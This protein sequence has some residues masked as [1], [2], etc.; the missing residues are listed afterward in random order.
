MGENGVTRRGGGYCPIL[1]LGGRPGFPSLAL[2]SPLRRVP[3]ARS[4]WNGLGSGLFLA[5][6]IVRYSH[7]MCFNGLVNNGLQYGADLAPLWPMKNQVTRL[8]IR[9][10]ARQRNRNNIARLLRAFAVRAGHK[11]D[12]IGARGGMQHTA[13][14]AFPVIRGTL[15]S[16]CFHRRETPT[17]T[18]N[19]AAQQVVSMEAWGA[20]ARGSGIPSVK[21]YRNA[22][23]PAPQ[24]GIEFCTPIPT[25]PGTGTP[26]E[27]RWYLGSP[28]V[29]A[30]RGSNFAA[31]P[32]SYI[33]NTQVP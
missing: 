30:R 24:R 17:Q 6:G 31:I 14:L 3:D 11:Q 1:K 27:A 19:D 18:R 33:K 4:D 29:V 8:C 25:T 21:A 16:P 5:H 9:D 15:T 12:Y 20:P 32:L 7:G 13:G 28:G 2:L 10:C 23:P 26:Y 22:V